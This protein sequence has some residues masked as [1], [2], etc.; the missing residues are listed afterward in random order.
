MMLDEATNSLDADNEREIIGNLADFY[1]G[2]AVILIAH[3]LST[4]RN[5]DQIICLRDGRVVETGTH[6]SLVSAHGYY[7]ELVKDQMELGT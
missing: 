7:H 6:E 1:R 5:S 4:V 3:R 2:R